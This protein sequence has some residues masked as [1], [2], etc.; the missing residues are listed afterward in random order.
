MFPLNNGIPSVAAVDRGWSR[1]YNS[2]IFGWRKS[3][4]RPVDRNRLLAVMVTARDS[5]DHSIRSKLAYVIYVYYITV[6]A[7][8][9]APHALL[10]IGLHVNRCGFILVSYPDPNV[11]SIIAYSIIQRT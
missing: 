4:G 11:R 10:V 2:I 1:D 7:A 9:I 8:C 6:L 5:R 3:R